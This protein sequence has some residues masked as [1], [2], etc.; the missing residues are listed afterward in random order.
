MIITKDK[1]IK[2]VSVTYAS[3]DKLRQNCYSNRVR[4]KVNF[5]ASTLRTVK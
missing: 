4:S 3:G 1:M 2:K 5:S